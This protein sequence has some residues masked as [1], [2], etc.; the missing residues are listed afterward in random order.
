M[1]VKSN[2]KHKQQRENERRLIVIEEEQKRKLLENLKGESV[3]IITLAYMYAKNFEETGADI[4][5]KWKTMEEQNTI[6]QGI[7]NKGYEE[8]FRKGRELEREKN[9]KNN[10]IRN[11][12]GTNGVTR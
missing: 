4:T 7:Y 12:D 8:G 9:S 3:T 2:P 11:N 10:N 6:L 1:V 5:E